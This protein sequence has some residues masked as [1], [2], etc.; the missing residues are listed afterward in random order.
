MNQPAECRRR[1]HP[2]PSICWCIL[3]AAPFH[4]SAACLLRVIIYLCLSSHKGERF[5]LTAASRRHGNGTAENSTWKDHRAGTNSSRS[6]RPTSINTSM[7]KRR[8]SGQTGA[9]CSFI[10]PRMHRGLSLRMDVSVSVWAA[11]VSALCTR[12]RVETAKS[13][14]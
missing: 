14:P 9:P 7:W 12:T 10:K 2:P 6:R 11:T 5:G 1:H 13:A 3:G 4:L 8:F